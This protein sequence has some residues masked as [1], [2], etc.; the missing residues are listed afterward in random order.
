MLVS[1]PL[2]AA[3]SRRLQDTGEPGHQAI[4][5]FMPFVLLWTGYQFFYW[6][7][8]GTAFLIIGALIGWLALLLLVPLY[9][10]SFVVAIFMTASIIGMMLVSSQ[11]G[12][13]RYGPN[14]LEV[15]P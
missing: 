14:P 11:P 1:V 9:L 7:S 12:P 13:N 3:M 4:Y 15:T 6:F 10:L 2:M 5:P 8:I